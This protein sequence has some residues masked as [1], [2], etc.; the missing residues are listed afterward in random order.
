VHEE[1]TR[2]LEYFRKQY[3]EEGKRLA[4]TDAIRRCAIRK[5]PLPA[6]A[7]DAFV[8]CYDKV[9]GY[10]VASWDDV[11]GNPLPD[12][13]HRRTARLLKEKARYVV[14]LVDQEHHR[15]GRA[16]DDQLFEEVGKQF[17]IGK[18]LCKKL[19]YYGAMPSGRR[20]RRKKP[21]I[22]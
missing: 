1:E 10:E 21:Q 22:S 9:M 2:W 19:Y 15:N 4:L 3:V 16:K 5:L 14:M 8:D 13:M 17:G 6:W 20:G 12:G 11:F 7:A 18:T